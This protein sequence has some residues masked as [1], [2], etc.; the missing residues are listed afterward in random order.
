MLALCVSDNCGRCGR[1]DYGHCGML[2]SALGPC[3]AK[4]M[5]SGAPLKCNSL[6]FVRVIPFVAGRVEVANEDPCPAKASG[7]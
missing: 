7:G 3:S 2:T 6:E 1:R 4:V 5:A